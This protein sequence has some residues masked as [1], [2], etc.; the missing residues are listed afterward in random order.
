M[1]RGGKGE[2]FMKSFA[3]MLEEFTAPERRVISVMEYLKPENYDP[4]ESEV[5]ALMARLTSDSDNGMSKE[6]DTME[7]GDF[8]TSTSELWDSISSP[9]VS[10]TTDPERS[11]GGAGAPIL[12]G[13]EMMDGRPVL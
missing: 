7:S 8:I 5:Q 3:Q 10:G 13:N 4:N 6:V 12:N 11:G 2:G 1:A 9:G